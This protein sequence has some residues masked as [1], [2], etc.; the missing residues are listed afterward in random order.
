LTKDLSTE[1]MS[2]QKNV[3]MTFTGVFIGLFATG[4]GE[5]SSTPADFDWFDY[6]PIAK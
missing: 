3:P 1:A 5:R 2:A 4:N 6:Q